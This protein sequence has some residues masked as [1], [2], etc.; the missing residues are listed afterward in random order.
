MEAIKTQLGINGPSFIAQLIIIAIVY[1]VLSK[2][3]FG[4][5]LQLLQAR[6]ARIEESE[7]N[8]EKSK[9]ER[10]Q[11]DAKAKEIIATANK[12]AERLIK[13]ATEIAAAAGERKK[14]EAVA[15]G[16]SLIAKAREAAEAER[17]A[18]LSALKRDFGR[19]V[20][21]ATSRVTGKVLTPGDHATINAEAVASI[22][23]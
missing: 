14:Q 13:E 18:A 2:Y 6:R 3:A 5:V 4:P 15:E 8:F 16:A 23:K 11:T 9:A 7:A 17:L 10:A 19:L 21:D 12:E 1:G 22:A 20:I